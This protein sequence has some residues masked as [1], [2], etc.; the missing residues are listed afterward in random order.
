VPDSAVSIGT[1]LGASLRNLGCAARYAFTTREIPLTRIS[2]AAG[3][4]RE[5][6]QVCSSQSLDNTELLRAV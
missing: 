1:L 6:H 3:S 2:S 4:C 5:Q